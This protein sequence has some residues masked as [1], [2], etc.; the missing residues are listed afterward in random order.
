LTSFFLK[1]CPFNPSVGYLNFFDLVCEAKSEFIEELNVEFEHEVEHEEISK[2]FN[3]Y[4][5][6]V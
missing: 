1:N 3:A 6:L 5:T 4:I 2:S